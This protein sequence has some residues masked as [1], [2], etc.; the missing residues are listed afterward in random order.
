MTLN[1]AHDAALAQYGASHVLTLRTQ[2]ALAH[3]LADGGEYAKA[4]IHL[5]AT[6][7]GLRKLGA[8]GEVHLAQALELLGD[9]QTH[10]GKIDEASITLKEAVAIREKSPE[11]LW[12][13]AQARER[14]GEALVKAGSP[15]ATE[16]LKIAAHDLESQLGADHPQTL[17][18]KTA[19]AQFRT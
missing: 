17:R 1:A 14:L 5:P 2:L 18:A 16:L 9:G 3:V 6:V 8:Q 13:L 12:E 10:L 11:D 15:A 7:D 19:L 4:Q